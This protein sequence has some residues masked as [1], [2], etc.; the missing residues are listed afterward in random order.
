MWAPS[1]WCTITDCDPDR[2]DRNVISGNQIS[3]AGS[4]SVD[5][6][7]GTTGGAVRGNTFDGAGMTGA[8][9]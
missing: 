9:S 4:E 3:G 1:N 6:E 7:E 5:I 2:S 8:D